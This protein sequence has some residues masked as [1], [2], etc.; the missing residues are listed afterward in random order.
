MDEIEKMIYDIL[1]KTDKPGLEVAE[2]T[3]EIEVQYGQKFPSKRIKHK[4][5]TMTKFKFLESEQ[6]RF[7]GMRGPDR[8]RYRIYVEGAQ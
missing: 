6:Y 1:S 8:A 5:D 7:E 3:R 2:V 4:M